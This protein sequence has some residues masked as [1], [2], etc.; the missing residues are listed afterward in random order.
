MTRWEKKKREEEKSVSRNPRS[1]SHCTCSIVRV[2]EL[3]SDS[4]RISLT[5]LFELVVICVDDRLRVEKHFD[6]LSDELLISDDNNSDWISFLNNKKKEKLMLSFDAVLRRKHEYFRW[7]CCCI[8]LHEDAI[9]NI[10]STSFCLIEADALLPGLDYPGFTCGWHHVP[11]MKRWN[12]RDFEFSSRQNTTM[13][14]T[15]RK[16]CKNLRTTT[17]K[18][19][20]KI[21]VLRLFFVW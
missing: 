1:T 16:I 12:K 8:V 10:H 17:M 15:Q 3:E 20:F 18:R 21:H 9:S 14:T 19:S 13:K 6:E 11:H 2:I 5:D 7:W 4:K